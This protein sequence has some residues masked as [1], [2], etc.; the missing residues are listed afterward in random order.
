MA[1][2]ADEREDVAAAGVEHHAGR[3]A[4]LAQRV[5]P[6][7]GLPDGAPHVVGAMEH[8]RRRLDLVD[9]RVGRHGREALAVGLVP[10]HCAELDRVDEVRVVARAADA[11]QVR[12]DAAGD[13]RGEALVVPGEVA[14]HEAAVAVAGER[15]ALRVDEALRHELVDRLEE[16]LRVRGAPGAEDGL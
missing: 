11:G 5:V 15:E 13:G 16:V 9:V 14:R 2:L 7:L 4:A 12:D 8:Q 1:R 6:L 3:D 10:R